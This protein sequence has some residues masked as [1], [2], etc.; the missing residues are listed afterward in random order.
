MTN[1]DCIADGIVSCI[2]SNYFLGV[3]CT[4]DSKMVLIFFFPWEKSILLE[5]LFHEIQLILLKIPK[6]PFQNQKICFWFFFFYFALNSES[7]GFFQLI[8]FL[9]YL[10][11]HVSNSA[12]AWCWHTVTRHSCWNLSSWFYRIA[13][14]QCSKQLFFFYHRTFSAWIMFKPFV[15]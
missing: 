4:L 15:F 8:L 2:L 3:M 5:H 1:C 6:G 7:G 13:A 12:I 14:S 11:R 9:Y 10:R